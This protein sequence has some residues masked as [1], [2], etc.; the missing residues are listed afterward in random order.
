LDIVRGNID[1]LQQAFD[2]SVRTGGRSV[3]P[4]G[5]YRCLVVEGRLDR[6]R[7]GTGTFKITFEVVEGPHTGRKVWHDIWLTPD[8]LRVSGHEL[9]QLGFQSI[10]EL[11]ER[12][13]PVEMLATVTV[14]VRVD[15]DGTER[16]R[17]R[18]FKVI[19]DVPADDSLADPID[20]DS[21]EVNGEHFDEAGFNWRTGSQTLRNGRSKR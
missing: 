2:E 12:S 6:A 20:D 5:T 15:D 13:L 9:A 11:G 19:D 4:A 21:P 1:D 10:R 14:V 17:V 7:T 16:N 3:I 8:A 18:S